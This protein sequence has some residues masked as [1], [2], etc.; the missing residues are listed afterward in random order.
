MSDH[1]GIEIITRPPQFWKDNAYLSDL[2][3]LK[4]KEGTGVVLKGKRQEIEWRGLK[5]ILLSPFENGFCKMIIEGSIH[6]YFNNSDFNNNRFTHTNLVEAINDLSAK[7]NFSPH[8]AIL[9]SFEFGVNLITPQCPIPLIQSVVSHRV[10]EYVPYRSRNRRKGVFADKTD[11]IYKIYNKSLIDNQRI[12]YMNRK[13]NLKIEKLD[14]H[15]LRVE[16]KIMKMRVIKRFNILTFADLLNLQKVTPLLDLLIESIDDTIFAPHTTD[17][18]AVIDADKERFRLMRDPLKWSDCTKDYRYK[19][20]KRLPKILEK[21][22]VPNY[23]LDLKDR[24]IAEWDMLVI[25]PNKAVKVATFTPPILETEKQEVATFTPFKC[26]VEKSPNPLESN[27]QKIVLK[28]ASARCCE[29]CGKDISMNRKGSTFCSK[30]SN[31]EAKK[32]RNKKSNPKNNF[33][34]QFKKINRK[35]NLFDIPELLP[36]NRKA[37]ISDLL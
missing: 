31:P 35:Q 24:V 37:W 20:L 27:N 8:E 7:L 10:K 11:Y 18:S 19:A 3:T 29:T 34:T 9:R 36:E 5:F 6:K 22:N 2:F 1:F 14:C 13:L 16:F 28:I 30:K 12:A 17:L 32:C 15:I 33:R 4:F 25:L 23:Q 26:V 21:C